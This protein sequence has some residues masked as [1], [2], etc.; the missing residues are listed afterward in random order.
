[1]ETCGN[2]SSISLLHSCVCHGGYKVST[3]TIWGPDVRE[4]RSK[5]VNVQVVSAR[6]VC[7]VTLHV[8]E[9]ETPDISIALDQSSANGSISNSS[10]LNMLAPVRSFS[11]RR[12][13]ACTEVRDRESHFL[14]MVSRLYATPHSCGA[15]G[16][17]AC[18]GAFEGPRWSRRR[19]L[20][21]PG[22][23]MAPVVNFDLTN[24]VYPSETDRP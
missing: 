10:I 8:S 15:T 17:L 3:V 6:F 20:E 24:T 13:L 4:P 2:I 19:I 16:W 9:K 14:W 1:L 18:R 5:P 22:L 23:S 11:V 7:R 21:S 12:T